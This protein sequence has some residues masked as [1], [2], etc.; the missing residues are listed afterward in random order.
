[1][2][3]RHRWPVLA[4]LGLAVV[5]TACTPGPAPDPSATSS[6]GNLMTNPTGTASPELVQ[7]DL[8]TAPT[9]RELGGRSADVVSA[10]TLGRNGVDVHIT[11]PGG[12]TVSGSFGLVTGDS[13]GGGGP[14]RYLSLAT[15]QLHD[16]AWDT[17]IDDFVNEFG[18]DRDAIT[19]Y[20]DS[21]LPA[22]AAGQVDPGRHFPGDERAGYS[23]SLQVRPALDGVVVAW[24]FTLGRQ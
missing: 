13:G 2:T 22:M 19:A 6:Q 21:A 17:F 8:S 5:L 9:P 18:G 16:G 15:T 23:S 3:E 12:D 4:G 20:L 14:V 1:M 10:E 24:K 11:L 7:W